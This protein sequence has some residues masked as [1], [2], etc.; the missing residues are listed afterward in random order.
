MVWV[1]VCARAARQCNFRP[2]LEMKI[3]WIKAG[4]LVPLDVGGRIRSYQIIR[5]LSHHHD[6][7]LFTFYP[8]Q[9]DDG[10]I[11]LREVL[12]KVVCVP[13][14]LPAPRS[15]GELTNYVAG[16]F[17]SQPYT[18]AKYYRPEV[19][20]SFKRLLDSETYDLWLCDF[21]YPAGIIPWDLPFPK[22][23][24][25]HNVEAQVWQ[26]YYQVTRSPVWRLLAWREFRAMTRA[27]RFYV[28]KADQL[29]TVS[30]P[31]R[32]FFSQY[33]DP[34]KITVIPTGVDLDYFQPSPGSEKP[35][36]LVFTGSM[37]W[38]PNDDGI[39]YFLNELLPRIRRHIP[40][41]KLSVVG[42][43]PS[44]NVKAL[45]VQTGA[46]VTGRVQDIRPY[47]RESA[48]YIVPL[49]VGGGT[50]LKIFEAM[51]M[52]KAVVSTSIGAEGLPVTSGQNIII[53]DNPEQFAL[54]VVKLLR[55]PAAQARLGHA[56]RQMVAERYS[57]KAVAS[58]F[59]AALKKAAAKSR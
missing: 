16:A 29:L 6:V 17:S 31:D 20:R 32:K 25:A 49:R 52:G 37:D 15:L 4:G 55:D 18:M 19:F 43:N 33:L 8:A 12:S 57:W 54:S 41:V 28:R 48:V 13:L 9:P 44:A 39:C 1:G 7:T 47:V 53:Q 22:V 59:D 11:K 5:E 24:F 50:R 26:R 2:R 23:L 27:E 40:E 56:A 45:A 21:I 42:R 10:H 38:L 46:E 51:A 34:G 14:Q 35:D 3:L 30:E 58:E 36:S